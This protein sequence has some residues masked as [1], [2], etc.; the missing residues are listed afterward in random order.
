MALARGDLATAADYVSRLKSALEDTRY[1]DEHQL[2]LARLETEVL[3]GPGQPA[4]ALAVAADAL[5]HLVVTHSSR[6]G[7]PLLVAAA[8][9]CAVPRPTVTRRWPRRPRSAS[10]AHRGGRAGGG[11]AG[12]ASSPADVR[13]REGRADRALAGIEP[14]ELAQPAESQAAWDEPRRPGRR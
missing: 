12:P 14:G 6:Y 9:A 8:R 2:A 10:P 13:G 4:E 1:N 5:D 11:G 3:H 7:W